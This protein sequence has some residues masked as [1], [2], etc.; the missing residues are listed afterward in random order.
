MLVAILALFLAVGGV[1]YAAT[2]IGSAQIK[3]N[4]IR[5][6]D[7]RDGT[8]APKDLSAKTR[9]FIRAANGA[10][11]R[12]GARGLEGAT[13][14]VGPAAVAGATNVVARTNSVS[15]ATGAIGS[16]VVQCLPGERATGGGGGIVPDAPGTRS[17]IQSGPVDA[18]G[19]FPIASGSVPT[20]WRIEAS[21]NT[22]VPT[23]MS[24]FVYAV[25][26]AP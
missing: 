1:G 5:S 21:N 4:S 13:G 19:S 20:G 7:V 8:L 9:S 26:A 11:G 17:L 24:A 23:P 3:N 6:A 18:S 25:C 15:V 12:T 14:P 10:R 16:P 2:T 22:G